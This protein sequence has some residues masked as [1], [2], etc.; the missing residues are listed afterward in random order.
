M[1]DERVLAERLISLRH[2]S[3]RGAQSRR[4]DSCRAGSNPATSRCIDHDH[5][6][7]PRAGGGGRAPPSEAS[8]R[9]LPR[10]SRRRARPARAVRAT[11]RGRPADR[12]RRLR[13]EGRPRRDDVRAQGRRA[14]RPG[15]GAASCACP[16]RSPRS[17]MSAPPTRSSRAGSAATS[18]SPASRPTCT[19]A[20]RRRACWRCGSWSTA[21]PRTARRRGS[22]DNAV[23]KAV[24]VFR[25][26][27]SL[28]F[29]AR[30]LGDVRPAVDQPRAGSRAAT[31]STRCPI[32][33][34]MS[35]DVRYPARA[36]T[37]RRSS[38]RSRAIPDDRGRAHVHPPA[39][40]A[41]R[42]SNPYVRALRDAVARVDPRQG[43][44]E[45]RPRRR[46]GRGLVHRGGDPRGRVRPGRR[47]APRTRGMGV[48]L[49]AGALPPRAGGLR[50]GAA[51][52]A[53][54]QA[55]DGAQHARCGRSGRAAIGGRDGRADASTAGLNRDSTA[56]LDRDA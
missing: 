10:P 21:A 34:P 54:A 45:R 13:H 30:V 47:R 37:R 7:L 25:A 4:Q 28:P 9:R 41:S 50:A 36:R 18:R 33:C 55:P 44:A 23:L 48:G 26:I 31:R 19:S 16:T 5:N 32:A 46:L 22:G 24:D 42:R 17:S 29:I 15:A 40:H 38:R 53:R 1:L 39:G 56:A 51:D 2:L 8:L 14:S 27:E 11:G 52:V 43:G 12:P 6:G 3:A 49:L 20:S 35:V